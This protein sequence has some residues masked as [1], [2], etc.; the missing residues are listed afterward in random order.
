[1]SNVRVTVKNDVSPLYQDRKTP[2]S[3]LQYSARKVKESPLDGSKTPSSIPWDESSNKGTKSI[4]R[5]ANR[6]TPLSPSPSAKLRSSVRS[7]AS[8]ARRKTKPLC[9]EKWDPY[10]FDIKAGCERCLDLASEAERDFF[11]ENGRHQRITRTS[12]GC[13]AT[14]NRYCGTRFYEDQAP[15]LCRICFNATHRKPRKVK[16][17]KAAERAGPRR[18]LVVE[19]V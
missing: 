8:P 15:R 13:T 4:E 9:A 14:C 3:H 19:Y 2:N 17:E 1:M 16:N 6:A 18:K 7:N 11:F 12:G 5:K 10:L